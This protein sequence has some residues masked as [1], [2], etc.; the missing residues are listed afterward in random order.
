MTR[1]VITC[2]LLAGSFL[3]AGTIHSQTTPETPEP[4]TPAPTV[5]ASTPPSQ[6][7]PAKPAQAAAGVQTIRANSRLVVVDVVVTDHANK[8]VQ[9][10]KD[11]D[12]TLLEKGQPQAISHFEEHAAVAGAPAKL[13]PMPHLDPGVF[14]NYS[15]APASGA[16]NILLLDSLN[17]PMQDQPYVREQILKY[18]KTARPGTRM[19]IFGLNRHLHLLQGFTSDPDLLRQVLEGKKGLANASPLMNNAVEGDTVGQ[20]STSDELADMLGNDPTAATIGANLQQFEAQEQAFQL[21]LRAQYTLDAL[22]VL[23]RYLS[24]LPGRKNLIWFSGSFPLNILPDGDLRDPFA[25]VASFADEFRET[26]NILARSQVAVYPIDARGL[27]VSPTISAA[28][29]GAKY[30]RNPQAFGKDEVKFSSQTASEHSTMYMM[31]EQTG[32]KAFVNTNGLKEAVDKAVESGSNY[33]TLTY[34]PTNHDWKGDF[35]KIEVKLAKKGYTLAYRRGYY[36]DDPDGPHKKSSE[37][38]A[39]TATA[40]FEPMRVAMSW[41]GPDPTEII[42]TASIAPI[43]GQPEAELPKNVHAG[44]KVAGPYERY[45]IVFSAN[46]RGISVSRTPDSSHQLHLEFATCVYDSDGA[47]VTSAGSQIKV[48]LN[49]AQ[50]EEIKKK[51]LQYRQQISVPVKGEYFLR[52]GLHDLVSNHVG[53]LELPVANVRRLQPLSARATEAAPTPAKP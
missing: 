7:G 49:E 1:R 40:T 42:F 31:A 51:G 16:L 19:A 30:A 43:T 32:G 23:G 46:P 28:N 18:L 8:P 33:Y 22:N 12:F 14:T 15:P 11:S 50:L 34:T 4:T 17:T 5:P 38:T 29:S 45:V 36:A 48:D 2:Y 25:I 20:D 41:G 27:M 10:L 9:N 24:G 37:Q 44:P 13:G 21:T 53:A 6:S 39:A 52:I 26:T 47:L 3:L 35:R